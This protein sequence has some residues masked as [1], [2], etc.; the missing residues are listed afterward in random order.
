MAAFVSYNPPPMVAVEMPVEL[1]QGQTH[2]VDFTAAYDTQYDISVE[3]DQK[4]AM[5]LSPCTTDPSRFS[6][7]PCEEVFPVDL[8]LKL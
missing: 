8:S 1:V 3:M 6:A 2:T 7:E 4:Q 5:R